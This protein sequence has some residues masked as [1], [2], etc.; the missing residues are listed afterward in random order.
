VSAL[1]SRQEALVKIKDPSIYTE[2]RVDTIKPK[3]F[4]YIRLVDP[5]AYGYLIEAMKLLKGSVF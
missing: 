2:Q 4:Y 5:I 1:F 3:Q